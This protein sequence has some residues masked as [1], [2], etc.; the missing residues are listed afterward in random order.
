MKR[1]LLILPLLL[2]ILTV[3]SGITAFAKTPAKLVHP[4][5]YREVSVATA[6]K[7]SPNY[8]S[9]KAYFRDESESLADENIRKEIYNKIKEEAE[10]IDTAILVYIG[11][12]IR[13]D[14]GVHDF[15]DKAKEELFSESGNQ[16]IA[17]YIDLDGDSE[18]CDLCTEY[19]IGILDEFNTAYNVRSRLVTSDLYQEDIRDAVFYFIDEVE[20]NYNVFF[21]DPEQDESGNNNPDIAFLPHKGV[22]KEMSVDQALAQN[23][24]YRSEKAFFYDEAEL[25][26]ENMRKEIFKMVE[27]TSKNIGMG[28]MVYI[29]GY[30][31][32]KAD[33]RE[34]VGVSLEK[35]FGN[36][37]GDDSIGLY[38]DFE[39]GGPGSAYDYIDTY[40][41]AYFWYPDLD[42]FDS[43]D[44][45][46]E[47]MFDHMYD[48]L[49][50]NG[51]TI[52]KS[53]V[54]QAVEIFLKDLVFYKNAGIVNG[55]HYK[56]AESGKYHFT[57]FDR[58]FE[59]PIYYNHFIIFII[60]SI[61]VGVI[62]FFTFGSRVRNKYQFR[63]SYNASGYT[64]KN[65]IRLNNSEDVFVREYTT[66]VKIESSSGGSH[67][68]G[69]GGGHSSS[70]HGGGR[71]R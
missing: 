33:T 5:T 32:D 44:N 18:V 49:P 8:K 27:D 23:K 64:S 47:R 25:F 1:K 57:E 12:Y 19:N 62:A 3:L 66:K 59:S 13:D 51:S 50:T 68:G 53:N 55:L 46:I 29:G 9:K 36:K 42:D 4:N 48:Y 2:A 35:L 52:Y 6:V 63:E 22:Y 37:D 41:D 56:V 28:V 10:S 21:P 20:K 65:R 45:R 60:I 7:T 67:G 11:G 31:R 58:I 14:A 24:D 40:R 61:I 26:D 71:S 17:L 70:H 39:G 43:S 38:L 15:L 69:G 30:Y 16:C 34:F 54:K